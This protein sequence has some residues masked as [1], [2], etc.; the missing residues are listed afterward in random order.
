MCALVPHPRNVGAVTA[1]T[2]PTPRW[3]RCR[4]VLGRWGAREMR[5]WKPGLTFR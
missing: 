1:A 4:Q 5:T 3:Q 2:A